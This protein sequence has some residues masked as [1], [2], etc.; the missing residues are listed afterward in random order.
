[1]KDLLHIPAEKLRELGVVDWGHTSET[2]P[3]SFAAFE[4]WALE[5]REHLPFLVKEKSSYFR[6]DLKA[7]YP[8]AQSSLVFLFS[9]A[10]T[11]KAMLQE[12]FHRLAGYSLGFDGADYHPIVKARLHEIARMLKE[13]YVF[14]HKHT[15]D[16]EPVLERDL[17]YR[18]GLGWFGKNSM[19]ISRQHGSYFI[20]G[21]L[22]LDRVLP[23][24]EAAL[25][26]DHCGQC[27]L[28]VDA[29]PTA[30]IDPGTRTIKVQQCISTW[31]IEDRNASAAVPSGMEQGRGELFGCDICQDVCP[32]NGK[33][34]EKVA[35][36]FTAGSLKWLNFFRRDLGEIAHELSGLTNR[37][38]LRLMEGS[39][40]GRPNRPTLLRAVTFWMKQS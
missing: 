22:I 6:S 35:P 26:T 15:H 37:G 8:E 24:D 38:F 20:I 25:D 19:L 3:R 10:P 1:M 23:I 5:A 7:W 36:G 14:E 11:K 27:R 34:L 31:T 21:S 28:C 30:A 16:T 29:C 39:P 4:Q 13:Q 18:A 40:F 32:W 2:A 33:P 9:Y 17:A 12:G